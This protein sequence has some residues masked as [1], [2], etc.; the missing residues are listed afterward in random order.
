MLCPRVL[1]SGGAGPRG[2]TGERRLSR[3]S[4]QYLNPPELQFSCAGSSDT[5]EEKLA[6]L[7][8][9]GE[10]HQRLAAAREL[11]EGRSR[12]QASN[13]LRY[14]A[15][16]PP[17]GEGFRKLQRETDAALKPQSILRDLK[18]GD[19]VWGTWLAFLRPHEDLVPTLLAGLEDKP[20]RGLGVRGQ[21][22]SEFFPETVLAL[23][24]SGDARALGPLLG[25]L[26][27]DDYRIAGDAATALGYLG[28]ADA[29]PSLIEAL[30]S[31]NGWRQV[32]A[33][34][35]LAKIGTRGS[36]PALEKLAKSDRPTGA[37]SVRGAAEFAVQRITEREK[38]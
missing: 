18:G 25:L 10:P 31:D 1:R 13:V 7:L 11:W 22:K 3:L 5:Q 29:E 20:P 4:W 12:R 34:G 37:L 17:G 35:A 16:P 32:N 19:Y 2:A 27:S 26:K 6:E 14:L 21:G 24:N 38:P 23:G 28:D 15:G 30:A 36:L 8:V 9:K 33:C